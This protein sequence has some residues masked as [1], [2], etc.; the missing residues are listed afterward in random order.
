MQNWPSDTTK[1]RNVL[2]GWLYAYELPTNALLPTS[3]RS[4]SPDEIL[5]VQKLK[6]VK[7]ERTLSLKHIEQTRQKA[8]RVREKLTREGLRG[9]SRSEGEGE[10]LEGGVISPKRR[11]VVV[12]VLEQGS[13]V[14]GQGS[15]VN[16]DDGQDDKCLVNG[17]AHEHTHVRERG[18][19][20]QDWVG[21]GG[22]GEEEEGM[23]VQQLQDSDE[24]SNL[25][26][27]QRLSVKQTYV[28]AVHRRLVSH[29]YNTCTHV[30]RDS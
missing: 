14:G 24:V 4:D 10:G 7:R 26:Q 28:F 16:G 12:E 15:E 25:S 6:K 20:C 17:L 30:T 18:V 8:A 1:I 23:E 2:G 27:D 13:E 22:E 3:R 29:I 5:R 19:A 9:A 11:K 21:S